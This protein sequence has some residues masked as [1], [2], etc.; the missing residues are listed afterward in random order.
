Q[1]SNC[2]EKNENPTSLYFRMENCYYIKDSLLQN[3]FIKSNES[4][5]YKKGNYFIINLKLP[6][7][8]NIHLE[9]FDIRKNDTIKIN[10]LVLPE[11]R[12]PDSAFSIAGQLIGDTISKSAL[13]KAGKINVLLGDDWLDKFLNFELKSFDLEVQ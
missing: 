13:L 3:P 1:Q 6:H 12:I 2:Q 7:K 11:K 8:E 9:V 4:E 5:V 10:T